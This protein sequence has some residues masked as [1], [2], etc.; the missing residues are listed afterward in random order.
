MADQGNEAVRVV[1]TK[2][3]PEGEVSAARRA[4]EPAPRRR[5]G[6]LSRSGDALFVSTNRGGVLV[7]PL[8]APHLCV[9]QAFGVTFLGEACKPC[10]AT[11]TRRPDEAD[12]QKSYRERHDD[13]D[14]G[15]SASPGAVL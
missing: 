2:R 9:A 11:A 6:G 1:G 7:H 4:D 8:L 3:A 13:R 15:R 10:L 5:R 14:E 12:D